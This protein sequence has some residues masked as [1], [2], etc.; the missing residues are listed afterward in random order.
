MG[1]PITNSLLMSGTRTTI[2]SKYIVLL[3]ISMRMLHLM[4]EFQ[5]LQHSK[6]YSNLKHLFMHYNKL[7]LQGLS[8]DLVKNVLG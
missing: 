2:L 5:M 1:V 7:I 4:H 6:V 3:S 8:Q